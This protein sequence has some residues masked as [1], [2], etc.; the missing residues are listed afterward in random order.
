MGSD[1][2]RPIGDDA[3]KKRGG[4][5]G[6]GSSQKNEMHKSIPFLSHSPM[7]VVKIV[8]RGMKGVGKTSL[9]NVFQGKPCPEH[10]IPS[11]KINTTQVFWSNPTTKERVK[12]CVMLALLTNL[13]RDLGCHG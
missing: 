10:Y 8:F 2:S 12:V 5:F 3:M 1:I 4:F 11:Q 6:F 13:D 7:F 9:F